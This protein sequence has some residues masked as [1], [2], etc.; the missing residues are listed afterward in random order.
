MGGDQV[1][2]RRE[3]EIAADQFENRDDR[4]RNRPRMRHRCNRA[5]LSRELIASAGKPLGSAAMRRES[6]ASELDARRRSY[7]KIP[8]SRILK[9]FSGC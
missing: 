6:E 3:L 7:R 1:H 9:P 2:N 5:D 8:K 4:R